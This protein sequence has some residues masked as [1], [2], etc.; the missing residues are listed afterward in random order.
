MALRLTD[1]VHG[2]DGSIAKVYFNAFWNEFIV[3]LN[4]DKASDY[5][6]DDKEDA[7]DTAFVMV[8]RKRVRYNSE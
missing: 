8:N 5:H 4:D 7:L 3:R 1:R 6:T 2:A